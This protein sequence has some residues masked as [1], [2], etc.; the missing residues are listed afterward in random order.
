M[1][2]WCL[3]CFHAVSFSKQAYLIISASFSKTSIYNKIT[4]EERKSVPFSMVLRLNHCILIQR[5]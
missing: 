1:L 3:G 2:V 4:I 5:N